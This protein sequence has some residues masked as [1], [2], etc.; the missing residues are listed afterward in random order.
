MELVLT[1]DGRRRERG[2]SWG[3]FLKEEGEEGGGRADAQRCALCESAQ[4]FVIDSRAVST[5]L[6][7]HGDISK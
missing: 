4:K 3:V 2:E 5:F 6:A 7:I 1:A